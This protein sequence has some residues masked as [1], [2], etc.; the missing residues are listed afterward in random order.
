MEKILMR[1]LSRISTFVLLSLFI[2]GCSN[3]KTM[4]AASNPKN[5]LKTFK[6]LTIEKLLTTGTWS[7]E[8]QSDDCKDTNW[9]QNFYK[10]RYY[11]S[12]GAA[13][14]IPN[15]FTVD[16]E[17]WYL[18]NQIL[19]ITNLS[20]IAAD[21]IILKYAI[22]YLDENKMILSSANYKYAFVKEPK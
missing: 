18:K 7:Y 3:L 17:S 6:D 8:R 1:T 4:E 21:D 16:A 11:K 22:D 15:A 12:V 5:P 10:N 14:L 9:T 20:P 13:C 2:S 19:Y